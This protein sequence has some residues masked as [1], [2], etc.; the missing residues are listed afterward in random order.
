MLVPRYVSVCRAA[1]LQLVFVCLRLF[2]CV[3]GWGNC[4]LGQYV[5]REGTEL[6]GPVCLCGTSVVRCGAV[7]VRQGCL[8]RYVRVLLVRL[9]SV[10]VL[11]P[12]LSVYLFVSV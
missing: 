9:V 1:C 12:L 5:K 7:I 10:H 8:V 11:A 2:W 4:I 3:N 6:L